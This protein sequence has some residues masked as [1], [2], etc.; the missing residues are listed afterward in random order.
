MPRYAHIHLEQ[1][2]V[3]KQSKGWYDTDLLKYPN[4]PPLDQLRVMSDQEWADRH[5]NNHYHS[6]HDVFMPKP[7]PTKE[8]IAKAVQKTAKNIHEE[9]NDIVLRCYE[10]GIPVPKE[11]KDYRA[12]LRAIIDGNGAIELPSPPKI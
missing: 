9:S 5:I 8:E 11:W 1:S 7:E 2:D 3:P 6:N 12:T 4:L 10:D